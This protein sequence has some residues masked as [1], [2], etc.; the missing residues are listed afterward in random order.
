[1]SDRKISFSEVE[2]L[3]PAEV[4]RMNAQ[5]VLC[6]MPEATMEAQKERLR[7]MTENARIF[8]T[9]VLCLGSMRMRKLGER[10]VAQTEVVR[11][12]GAEIT[13]PVTHA[14]ICARISANKKKNGAKIEES[15]G[16][17]L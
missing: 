16:L 13:L 17:F 1:M 6:E 14:F 2:V 3:S 15:S 9:S 7:G 5:Q 11:Q 10:A 12:A 4:A 8:R